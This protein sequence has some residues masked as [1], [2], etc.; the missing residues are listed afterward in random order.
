WS[1]AAAAEVKGAVE[2]A[3]VLDSLVARAAEHRGPL[4]LVE[5]A[6]V[7]VI[8][9]RVRSAIDEGHGR[10]V[11]AAAAHRAAGE[12]DSDRARAQVALALRTNAVGMRAA[13][14]D[15]TRDVDRYCAAVAIGRV[16]LREDAVGRV[17]EHD[18]VAVLRD[19]DRACIAV[20]AD[21][22]REGL[23]LQDPDCLDAE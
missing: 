8:R 13:R 17:A 7:A 18:N 1:V 11:V 15:G 23:L 19:R 22:A 5:P 20:A 4:Q 3:E 16:A 10:A 14:I 12:S 9:Q 6:D 21:A 2:P